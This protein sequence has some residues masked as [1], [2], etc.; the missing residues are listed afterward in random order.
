MNRIL[1]LCLLAACE[2]A[3]P[4]P[5]EPTGAAVVVDAGATAQRAT[6]SEWATRKL[7]QREL[8]LAEPD[9]TL[10]A[11]LVAS[12]RTAEVESDVH[13]LLTAAKLADPEAMARAVGEAVTDPSLPL[14][15]RFLFARW[16][17]R[18]EGGAALS[19]AL[20]AF[21]QTLGA[22]PRDAIDLEVAT[23]IVALH[24]T[25]DQAWAAI[26]SALAQGDKAGRKAAF[27]A[28]TDRRIEA[29]WPTVQAHL[30]DSDVYVRRR[31]VMA[32]E[33]YP[34]HAVDALTEVLATEDDGRVCTRALEVAGTLGA[35]GV[36]VL[37]DRFGTSEGCGP[38]HSFVILSSLRRIL[39]AEPDQPELKAFLHQVAEQA[40]D[41]GMAGAAAAALGDVELAASLDPVGAYDGLAELLSA[42]HEPLDTRLAAIEALASVE[43]PGV[44]A[45]L[46]HLLSSV[47]AEP[48][49]Q[50][51]V[52]GVL[53]RS[54]LAEP[55][56]G[57]L[58]VPY[59]LPSEDPAVR[60]VAIAHLADVA[61]DP[62]SA[63]RLVDLLDEP[64]VSEQ[65]QRG[66]TRI[67]G[68]DLGADR[69]A[70]TAA[71]SAL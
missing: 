14:H 37:V 53:S 63:S 60:A 39:R 70:W 67:V 66:L 2:P 41:P 22:A 71:V 8:T 19:P 7:L 48:A 45:R 38:E 26:Q 24:G 32:L 52:L 56:K 15:Q 40:V 5:V 43:A 28:L 21:A 17:A 3:D 18:D 64:D 59:T 16:T 4:T 55:D 33:H 13:R 27:A 69:V 25:E 6:A 65:A 11:G 12:A 1:I 34:E 54:E 30:A 68:T 51:A 44:H 58:A 10:A 23:R 47:D 9:P 49:Q 36:P 62:T 46:A 57:F 61:T 42:T 29:A 50:A 35:D 31:A 20:V